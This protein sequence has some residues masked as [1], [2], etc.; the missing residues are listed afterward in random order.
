MG[1]VWHRAL[2][3]AAPDDPEKTFDIHPARAEYA[4]VKAGLLALATALALT[5]ASGRVVVP[6]RA[7][8]TFASRAF[9]IL[10][11][12]HLRVGLRFDGAKTGY[13]SSLHDLYVMHLSPKAG[14]H[15]RAGAVVTIYV[16]TGPSGRPT[17]LPD[18]HYRVPSFVGKPASVPL[19]WG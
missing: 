1:E 3:R 14:S 15:V 13:V 2:G 18:L 4:A 6:R 12:H 9:Q 19:R 17:L 11:S 8:N 16:A 10:R 5:G 7:V